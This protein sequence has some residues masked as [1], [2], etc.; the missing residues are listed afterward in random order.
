MHTPT[1][2]ETSARCDV[3][4]GVDPEWKIV[5]EGGGDMIADLTGCANAEANAN[6][7]MKACRSHDALIKA[8]ATMLG[9]AEIDCMDDKSNVWRSAMLDAR[10][11]LADIDVGL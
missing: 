5:S 10:D 2:W 3:P 6:F 4:K 11:A 8:C 7:I 9:C 1:P